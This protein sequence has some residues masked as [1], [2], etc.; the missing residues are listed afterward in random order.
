[1][2]SR[3]RSTALIT[4]TLEKLAKLGVDTERISDE[5]FLLNRC[6]CE[7]LLNNIVERDPK[8]RTQTSSRVDTVRPAAL[9]LFRR[10][11]IGWLALGIKAGSRLLRKEV[12]KGFF[13]EVNIREICKTVCD[14]DINVISNS[15]FGLPDDAL[16]AMQQTLDLALELNTEMANMHAWQALPGSPIYRQAIRNGWKLPDSYAGCSVTELASHSVVG[17]GRRGSDLQ[18]ARSRM[19]PRSKASNGNAPARCRG[20]RGL[21]SG[22]ARTGRQRAPGNKRQLRR[23]IFA[24]VSPAAAEAKWDIRAA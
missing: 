14:A 18:S 7:P 20:A 5:M 1:V 8:L 6:H 3:F 13:Q 16:A 24:Q 2:A 12:S 15:I 17:R 11:G 21:A 19:R 4:A 22:Q 10:A 9:D 23:A